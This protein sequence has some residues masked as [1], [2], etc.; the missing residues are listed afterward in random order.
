MDA[1]VSTVVDQNDGDLQTLLE[2][3][4]QLRVQHEI[5]SVAQKR[6]DLALGPRQLDAEGTGDFV[7]HARVAVLR[8]VVVRTMGAPELV[9]ITGQAAGSVHDRRR[10]VRVLVENANHFGLM[11]L[12][13]RR[14]RRARDSPV[15][16]I[17]LLPHLRQRRVVA[18]LDAKA[19]QRGVQLEQNGTRIAHE[20]DGTVLVCVEGVDDLNAREADVRILKQRLGR[21]REIGQACPDQEDEVGIAC[22]AIGRERPRCADGAQ[23][24][25]MRL[26]QRSLA[27]LRH[28]HGNARLGGEVAQRGRG[29]GVVHATAGDDQ[30]ALCALDG[31]DHFEK[32]RRIARGTRHAV[33]LPGEE[34]LG[35]VVGFRLHVLGQADRHGPGLSRRGEDSHGLGKCLQDLLG[36][37]DA[38]PVARYGL[39]AIVHADVH[40]VRVFELLEHRRGPA[41]GEDVSRQQQHGKTIDRRRGGSRHHVRGTGSDRG[42]AGERPQPATCFCKGRRHVNHTLLVLRLEERQLLATEFL[43]RL[44]QARD[45]AV[46]EDS[47]HAANQSMLDAV[48]FDVLLLEKPHQ[49]GRHRH[50][51]GRAVHLRPPLPL[52]SGLVSPSGRLQ[53]RRVWPFGAGATSPARLQ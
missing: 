20:W 50:A 53:G 48:P 5:A 9:E 18:R 19:L 42:R 30:R 10:F 21:G 45:V 34:M 26:R 2:R 23:A 1:L 22:H 31:L 28:P 24:A 29:V 43:Q 8:V 13:R 36:A 12:A 47:G 38:I 11:Q 14:S 46:T 49:R 15:L 41:I 37:I 52:P 51:H 25:W 6:I 16:A 40:A 33:D 39:E 27:G 44:T 4:H 3:R 32:L 7:T 35:I 17:P